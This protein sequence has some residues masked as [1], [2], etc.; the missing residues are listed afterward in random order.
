M[1]RQIGNINID[2]TTLI[3]GI[4]DRNG[5]TVQVLHGMFHPTVQVTKQQCQ[6]IIGLLQQIIVSP[7]MAD[8]AEA[9]LLS[10]TLIANYSDGREER[11]PFNKA[12]ELVKAV[13]DAK[14]KGIVSKASVHSY[15]GRLMLGE[16]EQLTELAITL[17][18]K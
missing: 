4:D 10:Y 13:D 16:N 1:F 5:P 17:L 11:F 18:A 9:Q 6:E 3:F 7:P 8:L 14:A 12:S 15:I 2:R